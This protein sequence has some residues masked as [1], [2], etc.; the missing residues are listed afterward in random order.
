MEDK[1]LL[2]KIENKIIQILKKEGG[3]AGLDPIKKA[4][5]KMDTPK[6]FN[7][8]TT[9]KKMKNV[10]KHK[11][12]DYIL[13]PINED[14]I[15]KAIR[16]QIKN[17]KEQV[18]NSK[19]ERLSGIAL[20][21]L[22]N[23]ENLKNLSSVTFKGEIDYEDRTFQ[24]Q[25]DDKDASK[26]VFRNG[27][28][29]TVPIEDLA[30]YQFGGAKS[31]KLMNNPLGESM[32]PEEWE[33]AKEAER[34]AN[35][36]EK[37]K[38]MKIRQ[39]MD[40]ERGM[41]DY[42]KRR[43]EEDDYYQDPESLKEAATQLGYLNEDDM[44]QKVENGINAITGGGRRHG[45]VSDRG[46]TIRVKFSYMRGEF[47]QDEWDKILNYLTGMGFEIIEADND[48]ERNWEPEEPPES[49]PEIYLKK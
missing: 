25:M 10:E 20:A 32:S 41:T 26:F 48:Y 23:L 18:F 5:D 45:S 44:L 35:H 13:T 40:K 36:P 19:G 14:K 28:G 16:E 22:R 49:V 11:N 8:K 4:V 43:R 34:L 29:V 21:N 2:N 30:G 46:D 24:K 17:L 39:M 7:L 9:L 42:E 33:A 31:G 15:R 1:K 37:E 27:K 3:A 47:D 38:I 6:K 12:S